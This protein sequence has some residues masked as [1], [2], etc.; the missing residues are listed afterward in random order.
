MASTTLSKKIFL[1]N[2]PPRAGKDTAAAHL[3]EY[4]GGELVK[5]AAPLKRGAAAIFCGGDKALFDSYDTPEKKDTKCE[6]FLGKS[7]REVQINIS[8]KF[9]KLIH[10]T[11][12]FGNLLAKE[13]ENSPQELFF[14]SDSGFAPEAEVLAQKFGAENITLIRIHRDGYDYSGD[15]RSYINLDH[16]A[17]TTYDVINPNDDVNTFFSRLREIV[18]YNIGETK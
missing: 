15:S 11:E 6:Q 8:E 10:G 14:I 7:C 13:I 17:I 2:A 18:A 5:F 9:M 12:V 4:F 16:L 1:L 3:V